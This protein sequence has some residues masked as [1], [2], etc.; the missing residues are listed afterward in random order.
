MFI[1]PNIVDED[2]TLEETTGTGQK[3]D[4]QKNDMA[5]F[6]VATAGKADSPKFKA[7]TKENNT[8]LMVNGQKV[9]TADPSDS[10]APMGVTSLVIHKEC[11][12]SYPISNIT[13]AQKQYYQK[14]R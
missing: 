13:D 11:K 4:I 14:Q 8:E 1:S 5:Q 3:I 12:L 6:T 2:V 7:Y 9:Y 10:S